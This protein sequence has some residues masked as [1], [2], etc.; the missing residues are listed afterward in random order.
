MRLPSIISITIRYIFITTLITATIITPSTVNR[1]S[2]ALTQDQ[3]TAIIDDM[4]RGSVSV[5]VC[6]DDA[7]ARGMDFA[8]VQVIKV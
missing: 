6:S 4:R 7:F 1:Y 3:R 5:L 2:S 8:E